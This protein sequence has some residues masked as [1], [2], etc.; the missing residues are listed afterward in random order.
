M[1]D[2]QHRWLIP[3]PPAEPWG[4]CRMCGARRLFSNTAADDAQHAI[5]YKGTTGALKVRRS[6]PINL[7]SER[8][9]YVEGMRGNR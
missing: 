8:E 1:T 3:S 6:K 2:C 5:S 9:L 7:A 4:E